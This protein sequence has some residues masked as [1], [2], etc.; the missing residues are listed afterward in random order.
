MRILGAGHTR[1]WAACG[2]WRLPFGSRDG[3]EDVP[4]ASLA[5][6]QAGP[7]PRFRVCGSGM[8]TRAGAVRIPRADAP[9]RTLVLLCVPDNRKNRL[10]RRG[11]QQHRPGERED[12]QLPPPGALE[13]MEA[14]GHDQRQPIDICYR[15]VQKFSEVRPRC[16]R[17]GVWECGGKTPTRPYSHTHP[18]CVRVLWSAIGKTICELPRASMFSMFARIHGSTV[19]VKRPLKAS[20]RT[21][22][23]GRASFSAERSETSRPLTATE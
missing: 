13:W 5:G 14:R 7:V 23:S 15:A 22:S 19:P 17:L 16:R 11:L 20:K 9:V 18:L 8:I 3:R 12:E 10:H 1:G 2:F 4:V 21:V 6:L